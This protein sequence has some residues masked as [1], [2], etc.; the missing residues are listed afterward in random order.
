MW[1]FVPLLV[2]FYS[3][4]RDAEQ[5]LKS[6]YDEAINAAWR[7]PQDTKNQYQTVSFVGNNRVVFNI[8]GNKYRL[9]VSVAYEFGAV[10]IK[11]IGTHKEY[12]QIDISTVG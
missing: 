3:K 2:D 12:D 7:K 1:L 8:A 5:S 6:W 9:I 10:Y 4:R 11:F